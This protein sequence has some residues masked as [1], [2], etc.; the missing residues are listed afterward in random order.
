MVYNEQACT[1]R[2]QQEGCAAL[3]VLPVP[4]GVPSC[5]QQHSIADNHA[6]PLQHAAQHA[7]ILGQLGKVSAYPYSAPL[8]ASSGIWAMSTARVLLEERFA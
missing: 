1:G 2:D 4:R 5:P 8:W 7:F 6:T 3:G